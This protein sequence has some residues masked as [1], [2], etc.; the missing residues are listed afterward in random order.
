MEIVTIISRTVLL[1]FVI[2][3]VFRL[4]G[5]REIGELSILDLVIF[6]MIAEMAVLSIEDPKLPLLNTILPILVLMVIQI[7]MAYLSLKNQKLRE[8]VD[9]KP[10]ILINN[11]SIDEVEMRKQRYNFD[12]LMVQ[13][14]DKDVKSVADVEFAILEPS[15]KLSVFE[16]D[17][18]QGSDGVP[19]YPLIMDGRVQDDHLV[20]LNRSQV[21]LRNELRKLGYEKVE[22]ISYCTLDDKGQLFV[23][24]RDK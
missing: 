16:K 13:L 10:S 17:E 6:I 19:P 8:I 12:D 21:W 3:I 11:G 1:Y 4:M 5:K 22:D 9:G 20:L 15:G 18:Q 24:K 7:G 23:D 2:I 14:R